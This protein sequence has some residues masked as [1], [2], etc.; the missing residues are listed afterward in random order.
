MAAAL[1]LLA[2]PRPD[3]VDGNAAGKKPVIENL[4]A[5][6]IRNGRR[7]RAKRYRR[8]GPQTRPAGAFSAA[9]PP[10]SACVEQRNAPSNR[11]AP[12]RR[13]GRAAPGAANIRAGAV[14]PARR[15][16]RWNPNR[17]RNARP[18]RGT[19]A[20]ANVPSPRLASVIGQRPAIAPLFA[21]RRV[22][23]SVMCVAWIRHQR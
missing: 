22:S 4:V 17:C 3:A 19:A 23:S 15:S 5:R 10:A 6:E 9:P 13:C 2:A 11:R 12:Q 7:Y 8:D 16:A 21:I 14:P 1:D 20:R 18:L